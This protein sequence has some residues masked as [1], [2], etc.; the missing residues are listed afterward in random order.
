M[1]ILSELRVGDKL[2]IQ[3]RENYGDNQYTI[4]SQVMDIKDGSVFIINPIKQGTSY[5]LHVGQRLKIIFYREEKGIFR[6]VAEVKHKVNNDLTIY[7]IIPVGEPEKIQRRYFYRLDIVRKVIMKLWDEDVAIEGVTKDI[8][9]GGI[10]VSSSTAISVGSKVECT[11]FLKD[12]D[13]IEVSGE[14]IRCY[15]DPGL[16]EFQIGI[17]FFGIKEG[18]RSKIIAFIFEN[19][20]LL[21]KKGL[22]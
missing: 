21:R 6:F 12:N 19:Q 14:V 22:I 4:V 17:S 16:K 10:K 2:E 5:P 13:S 11:I 3:I 8:S 15:K 20:R 9:G 7:E 18:V 1:G